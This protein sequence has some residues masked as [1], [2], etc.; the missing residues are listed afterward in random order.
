MNAPR[1]DPGASPRPPS[2]RRPAVALA[3]LALV[4]IGLFVLLRGS[5]EAPARPAAQSA[6][7]PPEAPE[8]AAARA[9]RA[10]PPASAP[11]ARPGAPPV[12]DAVELEKTEVCSGEENLV[13][14]RAHTPDGTD[15]FLHYAIGNGTG[16]RIPVRVFRNP[17][18]SYELPE[19]SVFGRNNVV[20]RVPMPAFRVNDCEPLRAAHIQSRALPNAPSEFEFFARVVDV[21]AKGKPDAPPF[22]PKRY[23]WSFGDGAT[24]TTEKPTVVHS[25][26]AR[27]QNALYAQ[28][29]VT[30]EVRAE[31]DDKLV[32]RSSL[33][34]LNA[35]FEDFELK[36]I[37]SITAVPEPRFPELSKD[38]M[39]RQTFRLLHQ[40]PTPVRITRVRAVRHSSHEEAPPETA[41]VEDGLGLTE[42]PPGE[43][44]AVSLSLDTRRE[45]DLFSITYQL[46]GV[47]PEGYAVR[48]SFS[49]MRPPPPPTK[50]SNTPVNDPALLAKIKRARELLRQE[51]V[52]DE[53]IWR[54]EREGKFSDLA[55]P[56]NAGPEGGEP[57]PWAEARRAP[58]DRSGHFRTP[59][60]ARGSKEFAAPPLCGETSPA[61]MIAKATPVPRRPG[62]ARPRFF[63]VASLF[64]ASLAAACAQD[65]PTPAASDAEPTAPPAGAPA[66]EA[67]DATKPADAAK[68]AA[69]AKPAEGAKG[70]DAAK[71][72][73]GAKPADAAKGA[74]AP[75]AEEGDGAPRVYAKTRYV[76]V[77]Y[78][79]RYDSGWTG[80]LWLGGSAK[81]RSTT[82]ARVG[83]GCSWYAV[84]P[85]G[86]VCVDEKRATL[87]ANDPAL[88]ALL[89]F[90][91]RLDRAAP[92]H[93]GESR[94]TP[95]YRAL[96]TPSEQ[97]GREG[98]VGA[99][100]AQ[101]ASLG[102]KAAAAGPLRG[103]DPTPATEAPPSLPPLPPGLQTDRDKLLEMSTASWSA[104]ALHNGRSWLLGGDFMWVPK[105]RVSPYPPATFHGVVLGDEVSLPLAFFRGKDRPKYRKTEGGFEPTGESWLRLAHVGLT[106][107]SAREGGKKFLET[108]E[109]GLYVLASEAVVF[110]PRETTPWGAKVGEPDATGKAPAGRA[111]WIDA[112]VEGGW[113]IAYEGTRPAFATMIA[114]GR[115]GRPRP[116]RPTLETASTPTGRYSINGKFATATM[117]TPQDFVHSD[118]PWS[119]TFIGPYAIH[120]AYW[121]DRWGEL[122]SAGCVNLSLE[123]ARWL[124]Y[125]ADPQ[126]PDGWHGVR[127][128]PSEGPTTQLFLRP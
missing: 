23:L 107:A 90:A 11:V 14:I 69:A 9:E 57:L 123:D 106:G 56:P 125:W 119:L 89:P 76:W 104:E 103:V 97:R 24:E 47:S 43:G 93:Y 5:G 86:Y 65:V 79:P 72:A 94:E 109:N 73:E 62:A 19:I 30:V 82:P 61:P 81:L 96:P 101:L 18:G 71:P 51:F 124:F 44:T 111:T 112:S 12:V 100:L 108:K 105:D 126:L 98:D 45:P 40:R 31:N 116:G 83:G 120:G 29:L 8:A 49:L 77:R 67:A 75:P 16:T 80:F 7:A 128:E 66:P 52:T 34:L 68:G 3:A 38:G 115:G 87:D 54:L 6:S 50:D 2:R 55:A 13:T 64:L 10:A 58:P 63:S 33:Q 91:P 37:V 39:L 113:L 70:A 32:G 42:I 35:S 15:P 41:A 118:V 26:R 28:L 21:G 122:M 48:G 27:P 17:D 114:P 59:L 46:E 4:A 88:K 60:P 110:E 99:R 102:G 53:D 22:R 117:T 25:Y 121:H 74:D 1:L 84:E 36:R 78:E 85:R 20:T 127:W 95:R 92:H